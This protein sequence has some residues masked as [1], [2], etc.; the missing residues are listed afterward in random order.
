MSDQSWKAIQ[1]HLSSF[2]PD[3]MFLWLLQAR[4]AVI[5]LLYGDQEFSWLIH[6]ILTVILLSVVLLLA[7]FVPD[8]SSVFGVVGVFYLKPNVAALA[9]RVWGSYHAACFLSNSRASPLCSPG[10]TTSSCLL[11]VFPGIFY[12]KISN[13]PRRSV[14]SVGVNLLF[15]DLLPI[16]KLCF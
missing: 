11:F 13:Q 2:G 3:L 10:S 4:K 15:N 7:I 9:A 5:S 16:T 1:L 14:D 6:V 12:L 8:I